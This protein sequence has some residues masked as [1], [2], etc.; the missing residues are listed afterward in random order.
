MRTA[1]VLLAGTVYLILVFFDGVESP[2][3][4]LSFIGLAGYELLHHHRKN[5]GPHRHLFPFRS[6]QGMR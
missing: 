3:F 4:A 6:K 5:A 2:L 1:A